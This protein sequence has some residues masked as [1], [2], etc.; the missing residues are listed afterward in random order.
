VTCCGRCRARLHLPLTADNLKSRWRD[1]LVTTERQYV[2][3]FLRA[4]DPGSGTAGPSMGLKPGMRGPVE[5]FQSRTRASIRSRNQ[6][7]R[8]AR[9]IA[10]S[11]MTATCKTCIARWIDRSCRQCLRKMKMHSSRPDKSAVLKSLRARSEHRGNLASIR[12]W[13]L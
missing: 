13:A 9:H 2:L 12:R 6:R 1:V 3:L 5:A 10:P 11:T 4:A 7:R 8:I